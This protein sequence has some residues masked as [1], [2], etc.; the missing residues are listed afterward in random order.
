MGLPSLPVH[1]LVQLEAG[2]AAVR[3][4]GS[5]E[6]SVQVPQAMAEVGALSKAG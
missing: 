3:A 4:K 6:L 1:V 5:A 2:A